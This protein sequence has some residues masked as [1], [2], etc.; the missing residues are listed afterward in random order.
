[1]NETCATTSFDGTTVP[2]PTV[3][4]STSS[5]A[6]RKGLL[7]QGTSI[8]ALA[9]R[10]DAM[11]LTAALKLGAAVPDLVTLSQRFEALSSLLIEGESLAATRGLEGVASDIAMVGTG[12]AAE[13]ETLLNLISLNH[14]LSIRIEEIARNIR[15]LVS[16]VANVKIEIVSIG[17]TES[18]P[19]RFRRQPEAADGPVA[20]HPGDLP[21]DA[22][23]PDQAV[24][25]RAQGAELVSK[26]PI[27]LASSPPPPK[28]RRSSRRYRGAETSSR[29]SPKR[30]AA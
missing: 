22:A 23:P 29:A 24:A 16:V 10:T 2:D 28:S 20:R 6:D 17:T 26:A 9:A 1:M 4:L 14:V 7:A 12:L 11:C 15:F 8:A 3:A 25:Q 27:R 19:R 21:V 5:L 18:A 30:S 13:R